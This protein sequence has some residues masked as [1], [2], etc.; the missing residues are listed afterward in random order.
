MNRI[1]HFEFHE[2]DVNKAIEFYKQA[3]GWKFTKW[4]GPEPYWLISTGDPSSRG[5]DGGMLMSRDGQPRTVNTIQVENVDK[6]IA[7]LTKAGG[8]IVVPKMPIPGVGYLAYFTDP[9][10]VIV[11]IMHNDPNAK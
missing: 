4:E 1:T 11:G 2:P 9:G 10:G 6:A 7:D 5:I 3:F 8:K